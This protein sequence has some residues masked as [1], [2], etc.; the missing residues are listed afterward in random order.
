VITFFALLYYLGWGEGERGRDDRERE[1][2]RGRE[3]ECVY[4]CV[5]VCAC[6]REFESAKERKRERDRK[7]PLWVILTLVEGPDS[8]NVRIRMSLRSR[9]HTIYARVHKAK[10]KIC[11]HI[12]AQT[13]AHTPGLV[14]VLV[15]A[16]G[17]GILVNGYSA[18]FDA[19]FEEGKHV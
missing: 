15:Q 1:G 3:R 12:H 17:H 8:P 11:T 13:Y 16:D 7:T 2:A 5:C 18:L 10:D 19:S 9:Q 6:V 4:V 14:R